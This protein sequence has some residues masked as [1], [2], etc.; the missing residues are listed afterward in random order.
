M[1]SLFSLSIYLIHAL[2]DT[3]VRAALADHISTLEHY[4]EL[5]QQHRARRRKLHHLLMKF[6]VVH[7]WE[8]MLR[9]INNWSSQGYIYSLGVVNLK[10][11]GDVLASN[12]KTLPEKYT[13]RNNKELARL[14]IS[15]VENGQMASAIVEPCQRAKEDWG[16]VVLTNLVAS[17]RAGGTYNE[18][19]YIEFH[20]LLLS[21][22]LAYGYALSALDGRQWGEEG[23]VQ[24]YT[25]V[26]LCA[27]LLRQ[28]AS[29]LMIRQHLWACRSLLTLPVNSSSLLALYRGYTRFSSKICRDP[30]DV[31]GPPFQDEHAPG[32]DEVLLTWIRLQVSHL[33]ALGT[34]TRAFGYP[35]SRIPEVS[36]LAVQMPPQSLTMELWTTT[37]DK[38]FTDTHAFSLSPFGPESV[39]DTILD[40]TPTKTVSSKHS[41][42]SDFKPIHLKIPQPPTYGNPA[43]HCE[44]LLVSFM[45]FPD[46][47]P[48]GIDV[49]LM[50]LLKV[51]FYH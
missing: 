9:R 20:R 14:V 3:R 38:L 10:Q 40:H 6:L 19:T 15:M 33:L 5:H 4:L 35:T 47:I 42:F 48:G 29:S 31:D 46:K 1:S 34:I 2:S 50:E 41:V 24:E 18:T 39:K 11:L 32:T 27:N 37:V 44:T 17:L 22:L 25:R 30:S 7:C 51:M 13:K 45:L 36:L 21:T 26:Y 43:H 23:L 49:G 8:K 28:I 12:H 16:P